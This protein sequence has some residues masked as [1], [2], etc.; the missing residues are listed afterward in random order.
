MFRCQITGKMSRRGDPRIGPFT[1][2]DE[3]SGEDTHSS[4][5]VHRIVVETREKLYKRRVFNET[6]RQPEEIEVGRGHEIVREIN[7]SQEG[8][9]L[10]SSW[11]PAQQDVWVKAKFGGK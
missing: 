8:F 5:K 7:A 2:I 6:T 10:W 3:K 11:S 1:Y 4:E 9:D